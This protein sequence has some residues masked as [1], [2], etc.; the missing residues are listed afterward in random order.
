MK[1]KTPFLLVLALLVITFTIISCGKSEAPSNVAENFY[2]ALENSNIQKA[3]GLVYMADPE[4]EKEI[5]SSL[6]E[7]MGNSIEDNDGIKELTFE[8]NIDKENNMAV[9]NVK[10][11]YNNDQSSSETWNMIEKDGLWMLNLGSF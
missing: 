10:I 2:H 1:R 6:L 8:E 5:I 4:F 9:V 11:L 7:G 3:L